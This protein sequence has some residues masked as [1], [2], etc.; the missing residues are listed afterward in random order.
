MLFAGT[1]GT[2]SALTGPG[3]PAVNG[4]AEEAS[5]TSGGRVP[6][7]I[8]RGDHRDIRALRRQLQSGGFDI[9][10]P[11]LPPDNQ[12]VD[13]RIPIAG[14]LRRLTQ[15][16]LIIWNFEVGVTENPTPTGRSSWP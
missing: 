12:K 6:A 4:F 3:V 2:A 15:G 10:L 5:I 8:R 9:F 11:E 16:S 13:A 7:D 14:I 1:S